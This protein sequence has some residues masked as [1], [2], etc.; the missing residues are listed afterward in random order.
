[1]TRPNI[2]RITPKSDFSLGFSCG[3][4]AGAAVGVLCAVVSIVE[5][6]GT[7]S[8][9]ICRKAGLFKFHVFE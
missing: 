5:S 1:M 4:R 7:N 3:V 8:G 6:S 9:K 2:T